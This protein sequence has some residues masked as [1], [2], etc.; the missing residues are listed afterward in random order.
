MQI[1]HLYCKFFH[2]LKR[3]NFDVVVGHLALTH[4]MEIMSEPATNRNKRLLEILSS[5]TFSLYYLKGKDRILSD[6][7]SR[8]KED[9]SDPHEVI[10][11]SF[12]SHSILTEH[13]Y[14]FFNLPTETYK[15][16]TRFQTKVL[17]NQMPKVHGVDKVVD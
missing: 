13:N 15:A 10:P 7:L 1:G 4:I 17:G 9:R 14:S 6:I 12:N 2:L 11:I 5:Y 3:V 8:M 16:V